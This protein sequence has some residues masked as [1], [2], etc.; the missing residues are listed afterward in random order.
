MYRRSD[1]DLEV[2]I[3]HPGGPFWAKKDNGA[4]SK[5]ASMKKSRT[6]CTPPGANSM[7][8]QDSH[9]KGIS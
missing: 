7:K 2:F 6:P 5:R 4:W 1:A 3:V 8:R 9:P